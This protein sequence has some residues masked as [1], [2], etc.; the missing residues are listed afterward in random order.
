MNEVTDEFSF[1]HKNRPS[2][3]KEYIA[4]FQRYLN[5][6]T[7]P[8]IKVIGV[9]GGGC[10]AVNRMLKDGIEGVTFSACDTDYEALKQCEVPIQLHLGKATERVIIESTDPIIAKD[11]AKES[12]PDLQRFL[13]DGTKM[14]LVVAGMG[15]VVGTGAAPVVA[16]TA[17][18]RGLLTVGI[19]TIPFQF[20]GKN[21]MIHALKGVVEMRESVDTLFVIQNEKLV[22][23]YG[24]MNLPDRL[25]KA[26]DILTL[27]VKNIAD[28]ITKSGYSNLDFADASAMFKNGG[29]AIM[30]SGL[31]EGEGRVA[32]AF[33]NAIHS[34]LFNNNDVFNA[35][36]ILFNI[37]FNESK[38]LLMSELNE[39]NEFMAKSDMNGIEVIWGAA[40]D[41]TLKDKIKI[42]LL[43]TG[44]DID[45]LPLMEEIREEK[46]KI[47]VDPVGAFDPVQP[48]L[49]KKYYGGVD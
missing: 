7:S 31:G 22:E 14:V 36:K 49:V 6:V 47:I 17:K 21:K 25:K 12:L 27:M 19:V 38:Q 26:D 32:A 30:N 15:G 41:D 2:W 8:I 11:A 29:V 37:Y 34:P 3:A 24:D 46:G 44:F 40:S 35:R 33:E 10:N 42:I 9:G 23:I 39:I 1:P 20:E 48:D 5:E 43:A 13:N 16:Q 18:E 45:N 28:I 4:A